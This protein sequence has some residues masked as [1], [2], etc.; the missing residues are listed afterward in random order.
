MT[1]DIAVTT[2]PLMTSTTA[3]V[4]GGLP[5]RVRMAKLPP[6]T[7]R[8]AV[9]LRARASLRDVASELAVSPMTVLRWEQGLSEPRLAHA[10]AYRRLLD[11][12]SEAAS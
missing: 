6:P 1:N 12:L 3:A 10:I 4:D 7:M 5:E 11:A 8:R 9:R 2:V